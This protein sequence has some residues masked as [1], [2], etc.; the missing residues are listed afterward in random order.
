MQQLYFPAYPAVQRFSQSTLSSAA[1]QSTLMQNN[2]RREFGKRELKKKK[3]TA[4][5]L[6]SDA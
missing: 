4:Y 2:E 5:D 3:K 1:K 6:Q